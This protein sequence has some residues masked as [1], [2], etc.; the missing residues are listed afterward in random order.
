MA[1]GLY[2]AYPDQTMPRVKQPE[3]Y[4]TTWRCDIFSWDEDNFTYFIRCLHGIDDYYFTLNKSH[5]IVIKDTQDY[6]EIIY[7]FRKDSY[8]ATLL[9]KTEEVLHLAK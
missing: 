8:G 1:L 3:N 4:R 5:I 9:W 7:H 6:Y 2:L